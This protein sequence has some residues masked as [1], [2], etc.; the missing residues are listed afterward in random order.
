MVWAGVW[1]TKHKNP[2]QAPSSRPPRRAVK[3]WKVKTYGLS[4]ESRHR[5]RV[6]MQ[7]ILKSLDLFLESKRCTLAY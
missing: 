2:A 3:Q 5:D 1:A 4:R 7:D 6:V